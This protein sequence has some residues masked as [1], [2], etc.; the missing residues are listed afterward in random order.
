MAAVVTI[1]LRSAPGLMAGV[2]RAA[3]PSGRAAS[4]FSSGMHRSSSRA[5]SIPI[6]HK[7]AEASAAGNRP[8][9]SE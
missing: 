4:S 9:G 3:C 7:L 6:T 8:M 1:A 2:P 5:I